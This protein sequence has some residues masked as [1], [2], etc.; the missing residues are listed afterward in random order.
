LIY[1]NIQ[2]RP[3]Q[4]WDSQKVSAGIN[5]IRLTIFSLLMNN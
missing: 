4:K 2:K 1:F 5:L 3:Q